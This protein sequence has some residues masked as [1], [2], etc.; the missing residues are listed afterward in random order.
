MATGTLLCHKEKMLKLVFIDKIA[1]NR[2]RKAIFGKYT[3]PGK[4]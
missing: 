2:L 4:K 1:L 3:K